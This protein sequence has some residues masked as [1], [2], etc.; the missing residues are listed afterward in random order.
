M[1]RNRLARVATA[2]LAAAAA[3]MLISGAAFAKVGSALPDTA[4]DVTTGDAVL[5]GVIVLLV[6]VVLT[7][8]RLAAD[9]R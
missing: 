6:G 5:S 2:L 1:I 9:R 7:A 8:D 3:T 4:V